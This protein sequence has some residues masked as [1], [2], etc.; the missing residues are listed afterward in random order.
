MARA[1]L[2]KSKKVL[3]STTIASKYIPKRLRICINWNPTFQT[4]LPK[5][6]KN[7]F[8]LSKPCF[9]M[10]TIRGIFTTYVNLGLKGGI[11]SDT[12]SGPLGYVLWCYG[13]RSQ[14]FFTFI[15]IGSGHTVIHNFLNIFLFSQ[16]KC[17]LKILVCQNMVFL[18]ICTNSHSFFKGWHLG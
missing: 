17:F 13:S 11:S 16:I 18:D 14:D 10:F 6:L 5:I 12:D 8:L 1:D 9:T 15:Q 3:V 4:S 7:S 2:N